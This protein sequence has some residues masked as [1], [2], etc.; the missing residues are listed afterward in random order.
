MGWLS[1][2]T[3]KIF[4]DI[5]GIDDNKILGIGKDNIANV[6]DKFLPDDK[7]PFSNANKQPSI[8]QSLT[9]TSTPSGNASSDKPQDTVKPGKTVFNNNQKEIKKYL[10]KKKKYNIARTILAS[11]RKKRSEKE[12][13]GV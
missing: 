5:L 2:L 11:Q 4:D 13:L 9:S 8:D 3:D 7:S 1:D 10:D 6:V 12:Y